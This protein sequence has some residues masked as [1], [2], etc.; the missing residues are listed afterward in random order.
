MTHPLTRE[1]QITVPRLKV[2]SVF[3]TD[4]ASFEITP[5]GVLSI[6]IPVKTFI[7]LI[8]TVEA[9]PSRLTARQ[10]QVLDMV[11]KNSTNKE[12]AQI[13]GMT[14]R[15]VKFHVTALLGI[16]GVTSRRELLMHAYA[17]PP[18]VVKP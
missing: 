9:G 16:F 10:R 12:I 1:V 18:G 13:L 11:V 14:E 5:Q 6:R 4:Q 7:E 2:G 17:L 3:V 8:G 15:T